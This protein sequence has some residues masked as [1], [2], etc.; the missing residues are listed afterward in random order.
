MSD[1]VRLVNQQLAFSQSH[2]QAALNADGF[3]RRCQL[4]ACKLQMYLLIHAYIAEIAE[5]SNLKWQL[6]LGEVNGT[7]AQFTEQLQQQD[8]IS[9]D[10]AH[11]AQ[12]IGSEKPWM[13]WVELATSALFISKNELNSPLLAESAQTPT[14]QNASAKTTQNTLIASSNAGSEHD[15]LNASTEIQLE[16]LAQMLNAITELIKVQRENKIEF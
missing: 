2:L 5:R 15:S 11:V 12:L 13:Y 7:L 6:V 1:K 14:A 10:F 3:M 9:S 4:Q 16:V 8:K